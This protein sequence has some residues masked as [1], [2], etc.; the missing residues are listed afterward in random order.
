[1]RVVGVWV[2]IETLGQATAK[3][4][5]SDAVVKAIKPRREGTKTH[6]ARHNNHD[7]AANTGLGWEADIEV[8]RALDG[9]R[10]LREGVS[11]I[12]YR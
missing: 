2:E 12:C 7:A 3:D 5:A 10:H 9:S 1:M 6:H 4:G 11:H 8:E